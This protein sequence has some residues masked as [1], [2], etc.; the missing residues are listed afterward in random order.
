MAA[1]VQSARMRFLLFCCVAIVLSACNKR[2][3]TPKHAPDALLDA[4][5]LLTRAD[6]E[7]AIG[8][9]PQEGVSVRTDEEGFVIW[10]CNF[11]L[12]NVT[13][14]VSL[15]LVQRGEGPDARDPRQVWQEIVE[16]DFQQAV[17]H[18]GKRRPER[19]P[20]LGDDAFWVGG[21]KS[22][23]LY[24]LKGN[25]HFRIGLGGDPNQADKI[26]KATELAR[27]VLQRM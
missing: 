7:K 24:V 3:A 23:G 19:V 13:D 26:A 22:G 14:S 4:C 5:T 25:R 18:R 17:E 20:N 16:R 1:R 21:R 8:Q 9:Q 27:A 2:E 10:Q 12:P 6:V 15:R 11:V